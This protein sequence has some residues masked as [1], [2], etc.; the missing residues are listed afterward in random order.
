MNPWL[1]SIHARLIALDERF[2]ARTLRERV[3][4]GGG[5]AA[6]LFL[7]IDTTLIQPVAAE[8]ER[9][10]QLTIATREEITRLESDLDKL[11]RVE[12]TPEEIAI[13]ARKRRI[14]VEL[15]E[16]NEQIAEEIADLVPP[17]AVVS[18]LE[19]MLDPISG[20]SLVRVMSDEPHRV[21]SGALHEADTGVLDATRSLYRHGLRVEIEGDFASTLEYL[22]RVERSEWH[23]LWDRFEYRVQEYPGARITIE[24]HTVSEQEEWIGV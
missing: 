5:L 13:L 3:I 20:L 17:E 14:E 18:V 10:E 8:L 2:R 6:L 16:V 15:A 12:L 23:L 4:L 1:S 24:L 7:A 11:E 21:G 9:V 22:E 19:D